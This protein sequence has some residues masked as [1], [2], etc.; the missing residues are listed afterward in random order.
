[1]FDATL[2][3]YLQGYENEVAV[4]AHGLLADLLLSKEALPPTTHQ[5]LRRIKDILAPRIDRILSRPKVS[6]GMC[7]RIQGVWHLVGGYYSPTSTK[8]GQSKGP[9]SSPGLLLYFN[10]GEIEESSSNTKRARRRRGRPGD[11]A[12]KGPV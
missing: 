3:A 7:T 6:T 5:K 9:A 11:E 8:K 1:M 4:E 2:Y 10:V 12:S